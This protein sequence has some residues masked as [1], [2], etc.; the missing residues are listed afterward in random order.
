MK[1]KNQKETFKKHSSAEINI[2]TNNAAV[3]LLRKKKKH[4][5]ESTLLLYT[6]IT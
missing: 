2:K 1:L 4:K 6:K 3:V 5:C